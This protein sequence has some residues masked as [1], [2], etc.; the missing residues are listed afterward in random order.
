MSA[1]ERWLFVAGIL[2]ACGAVL[3]WS[4]TARRPTPPP[5]PGAIDVKY[6]GNTGLTIAGH[7][8]VVGVDG[9]P[10]VGFRIGITPIKN[11]GLTILGVVVFSSDRAGRQAGGGRWDTYDE[12]TR[13]L[14][15]TRD[16]KVVNPGPKRLLRIDIV[17]PTTLVAHFADGTMTKFWKYFTIRVE[18]AGGYTHSIVVESGTWHLVERTSR[19]RVSEGGAA[20]R[21][22]S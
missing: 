19:G 1:G 22:V 7:G 17:G 5:F 8:N 14:G 16:G 20:R 10:D 2:V 3:L 9:E 12:S 15:L 18:A 6:L 11:E 13:A 21:P 4:V